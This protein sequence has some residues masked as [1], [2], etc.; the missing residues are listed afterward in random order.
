MFVFIL[1]HISKFDYIIMLRGKQ[2][3]HL[4]VPI[5]FVPV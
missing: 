5:I 2:L 1:L 3:I 4:S